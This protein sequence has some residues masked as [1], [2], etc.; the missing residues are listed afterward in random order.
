MP[1]T[2][3]HAGQHSLVVARF[4]IDHAVRQQARLGYCWGEQVAAGQAPQTLPPCARGDPSAEQGGGSAINC[5]MPA[6][7]Y[8]VQCADRQAT[9]G[10]A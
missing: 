4:D 9:S 3:F 10:K 5:A 7:G 1:Q 8:F 6:A 2:F